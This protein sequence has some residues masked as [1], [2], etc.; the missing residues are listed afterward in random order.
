MMQGQ[1][2][3]V[4][5]MIVNGEKVTG[6]LIESTSE[7]MMGNDTIPLYKQVTIQPLPPQESGTGNTPASQA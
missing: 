7:E 3:E 5:T 4:G 6:Y 1:L 2:V